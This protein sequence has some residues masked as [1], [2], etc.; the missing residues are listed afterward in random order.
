MREL[1]MRVFDLFRR[2]KLDDELKN[3]LAFHQQMLERDARASGTPAGGTT[4][5]AR[6]R[7]GNITGVRERAREQWSFAWMEILLQDL[8][9]TL[10]GLRR[11]P[12]FTAAV[13][14]TLGLGIGANA[15]MFG[16][17]DRLMFRPFPYLRDPSSVNRVYVQSSGR[18][19][20]ST[21]SSFQ[22]T[23]YLDIAR[24]ST[25]FADRAAFATWQ[26]AVGT[27]DAARERTVNGVSASFFGFFDAHP[28]AGRF[29]SA[30]EDSIP[31]GA[32]VAVLGYGYWKTEL[33]GRDV[34][35]NTIAIGPMTATIIGIAPP[36]FVGVESGEA[37]A[38]FV[39][40]TT[41][42]YNVGQGNPE[43]FITQYNWDWMYMMVRRKPGVTVDAATGDLTK[44]Y[45]R[46][47]LAMQAFNRSTGATWG[48]APIDSM[49]PRSIAGPLREAAGP[50]AGLESQTLLWVS[51]VAAIVLLIACANVT[52]LMF[53]RMLSRRREIAVRIALGVSR[54]RLVVQFLTE[55]VLLALVGCAAG[56]AIAQ[57]GGTALRVLV[58]GEDAAGGVATDPRTLVVAAAVALA[59]AVV[60]AV[61]PA[62]LAIR[63]NLSSDLRAGGR[64]GTAQRS[65]L[66][67]GLLVLQGTLSVILLVGA[68]SFVRSLGNVRDMH[69]GWDAEPVLLARANLRGV[70]LDSAATVAL[71]RRLFDAAQAIP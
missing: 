68:G 26:L 18:G 24:W 17:V 48:L 44:A 32:D 19:R 47:V 39:P 67:T 6:C 62:L 37:P 33:G 15:A 66:R 22:Y 8:R 55:S 30:A 23:A 63:G 20:V 3:E 50:G 21:R 14:V 31:R 46:S 58:L 13:V 54:R 57:W 34:I 45:V 53:A 42:V 59:S 38:A 27:G 56:V 65:P 11:A 28:V 70:K 2:D 40:I 5:T 52:N 35:G 7:L 10:R 51:G 4:H 43:R 29:F 12:G 60:V 69:M 49:K 9:Y 1:L 41:L 61:G 64:G 16:V 25:A 36:G 71:S